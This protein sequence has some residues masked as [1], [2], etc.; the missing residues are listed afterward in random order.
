[1]LRDRLR[2]RARRG[3]APS[4][5][6]GASIALFAA[7]TPGSVFVPLPSEP[8]ESMVLVL[9]AQA[10]SSWATAIADDRAAIFT[11]E[12]DLDMQVA[13]EAILHPTTLES[14][15]LETGPIEPDPDGFCL[16]F[17]GAR[18]YRTE[19]QADQTSAW[20]EVA[21]PSAVTRAFRRSA[22]EEPCAFEITGSIAI[23]TGEAATL[24]AASADGERI[25]AGT[26]VGLFILNRRGDVLFEE[27]GAWCAGQ[28]VLDT[29]RV[30]LARCDGRIMELGLESQPPVLTELFRLSAAQN[31]GQGVGAILSQEVSGGLEVFMLTIEGL[32]LWRA[33]G[34]EV[35]QVHV[36]ERS[37]SS[38]RFLG[39]LAIVGPSHALVGVESNAS[40]L[41]FEGG[42]GRLVD[43]GLDSGISTIN[44]SEWGTM[45]GTT[46]GGLWHRAPGASE[47]RAIENSPNQAWMVA[48]EP[49]TNG[50]YLY[51]L[52]FGSVGLYEVGRGFCGPEVL[53]AQSHRRMIRFGDGFAVSGQNSGLVRTPITLFNV[54][55]SGR[56][57]TR[58]CGPGVDGGR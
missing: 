55:R 43:V 10:A 45:L 52:T 27:S 22:I 37:D 32:V 41:E 1:M 2:A 7:C 33:P 15:G 58:D 44:H 46:T 19:V 13:L 8:F 16:P 5:L 48:V 30:V 11:P 12:T 24:L 42:V 53:S 26:S 47:F 49:L 36:F 54:K 28:K 39:G 21:G 34:S 35:A 9:E 18:V 4:A 14:L 23:P 31:G 20:M 25:V 6:G 50:D 51:A 40:M 17:E 56:Q 57:L 3:L 29:E 38:A